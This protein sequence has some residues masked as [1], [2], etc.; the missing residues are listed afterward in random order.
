MG[1]SVGMGFRFLLTRLVGKSA[2]VVACCLSL[3][4][5]KKNSLPGKESGSPLVG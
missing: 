5:P 2:G 4:L 1:G 3:L